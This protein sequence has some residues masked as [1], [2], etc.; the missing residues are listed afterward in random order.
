MYTTRFSK[1]QVIVH[2]GALIP[3]AWLIWDFF[4]ENLTA[5]PIQAATLRTGKT[6]LVLLVLTLA[7]TPIITLFGFKS[8]IKVRRAL[9]LYAFLYVTIHF[10][11]FI[12]WDYSFDLELLYEAIFEK[13]FALVGFA[14]GILLLPLAIT[15][16]KGWMKRL[17]KKWKRIHKFIYLAGILAVVHY[18]WSVKSD[19]REPLVYGTLVIILLI[20]RMPFVRR[21]LSNYRIRFVARTTRRFKEIRHIVSERNQP[22]RSSEEIIGSS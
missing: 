14:T 12:G 21:N 2:L 11:I 13:R 8:L 17:G 5:N 20:A 9:G 6:A 22:P 3:L 16:T 4:T 7:V 19:I 10:A 15:S 18:T 1:F